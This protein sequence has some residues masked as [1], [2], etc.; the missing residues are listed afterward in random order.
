[1]AGIVEGTGSGLRSEIATYVGPKVR[2][3]SPIN[4]W[5]VTFAVLLAAL[6]VSLLLRDFIT[7]SI[8]VFFFFG[9]AFT[10]WYSGLAPALVFS[11]LALIATSYFLMEP[12]GGFFID[13]STLIMFVALGSTAA[14]ISWLTNSLAATR[15]NLGMHA[16]QLEEQARDLEAQ[17]E[18]SR[19]LTEQLE[20]TNSD[21]G[22]AVTRAEAGSRAKTD[23]L[24]V[25]SHELRTPLNAIIGYADLLQTEVPGPLTEAQ[26]GHL[27]RIRSSSF[28][29][30]DLIQ[31]VLSFSRIEAGH[32]DLRIADVDVQKLA[33]DAQTYVEQ[34]CARKGLQQELHLPEDRLVMVTDPAKLR[35][36]L[37][38]L[39]NNAC[40]FTEN[41]HVRLRVNRDRDHVVFEVDDSGP[42][43][44]QE[45]FEMIFEPFTQVDQ[46]RTR[47]KDG[48]GLGL[49]VS[50][51]LA[52]LLGGDLRVD[53]KVGE[54]STFT[55]RLP[56]K[57]RL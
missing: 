52:H 33:R 54:G 49:P 8:F 6:G 3:P 2:S 30:L 39:L 38:N 23:F 40:K 15:T 32:E 22:D 44:A 56:I 13:A 43:I 57:T 12:F 9:L 55:L 25:M 28:H 27:G 19:M 16:D 21:L 50:R 29:L 35:Q 20:T 4:R 7:R 24:A 5:L 36:I 48:A 37:L 26:R 11:A 45:N 34:E 17:M 10:A 1:M 53:S 47:S 18:E 51:R 31:D 14:F 42:G 41:G 46:S